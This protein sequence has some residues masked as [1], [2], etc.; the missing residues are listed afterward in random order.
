VGHPHADRNRDKH[1]IDYLRLVKDKLPPSMFDSV[2]HFKNDSLAKHLSSLAP[3]IADQALQA[4]FSG[5]FDA[6]EGFTQLYL[7]VMS[8][9]H[10]IYYQMGCSSYDKTFYVPPASTERKLDE[11]VTPANA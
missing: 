5:K 8:K 4:R 7:F 9:I 11:K 6:E 10:G 1:H 3:F 2:K